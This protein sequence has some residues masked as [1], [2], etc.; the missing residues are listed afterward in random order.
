MGLGTVGRGN[1]DFMVTY[2]TTG[3]ESR[4][5]DGRSG[6][7]FGDVVEYSGEATR[8]EENNCGGVVGRCVWV[9]VFV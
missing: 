9:R 2:I 5:R 4:K 8:V 1:S 3:D 7:P 6:G